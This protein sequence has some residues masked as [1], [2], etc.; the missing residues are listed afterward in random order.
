MATVKELDAALD[1]V[2]D[3]TERLEET[4]ASEESRIAAAETIAALGGGLAAKWAAILGKLE[5]IPR[6]GHA[7]IQTKSGG[8]YSYDYVLES[9]LMAELRPLLAAYGVAAFYSDEILESTSLG[10]G[11]YETRVRVYLELVD[12]A[13]QES[14]TLRS[15]DSA[16]DY[17]DKAA[18]KAK[19]GAVRYLLLKGTLNPSDAQDD[20]DASENAIERPKGEPATQSTDRP[21]E[22]RQRSTSSGGDRKQR[23]AKRVVDLSAEYDEISASPPGTTGDGIVAEL[24]TDLPGLSEDWLVFIGQSLAKALADAQAAKHDNADADVAPFRVPETDRPIPF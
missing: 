7:V 16:A 6:N 3:L 18:R 11:W 19:T 20:P 22:A 1:R 5:A 21:A 4:R 14:K 15:D 2:R 24:G 9:D 10:Q 8:E 12:G 17:G 23:L 13:T